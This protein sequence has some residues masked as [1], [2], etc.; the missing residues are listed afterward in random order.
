MLEATAGNGMTI[1]AET[2]STGSDLDW[3]KKGVAIVNAH[4]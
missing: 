4:L 1:P 3:Y 2:P